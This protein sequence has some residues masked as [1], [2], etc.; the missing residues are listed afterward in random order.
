VNTQWGIGCDAD[1]LSGD[2]FHAVVQNIDADRPFIGVAVAAWHG[3]EYEFVN[4]W[5]VSDDICHEFPEPPDVWFTDTCHDL[6]A[7]CH[8]L[9]P[10][11][12]FGA[13]S[14]GSAFAE[15]GLV[16]SGLSCT[17]ENKVSGAIFWDTVLIV[18]NNLRIFEETYQAID[19]YGDAWVYVETP[20]F[21]DGGTGASPG[22]STSSQIR[23]VGL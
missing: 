3:G 10:S 4:V 11:V 8:L 9:D 21:V 15:I 19:Y 7:G 2:T 6:A 1:I 18:P 5:A 22:E 14:Y 17:G 20:S 23:R 16:T 13:E 12:P